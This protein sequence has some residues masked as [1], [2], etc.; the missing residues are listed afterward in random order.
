MAIHLILLAV[1]KCNP[2]LPGSIQIFSNCLGALNKMENLP[3]Y[4]IPTKCSHSDI[5]KNIMVHCSDL[6]FCWLY[7]HVKAHQDD[8]IQY[9]DLS[10]LAQLNYQMDYHAKKA[11]WEAGPVDEEI[12][13]Q[14]PFEPVYIFLGKNK[15]TSDKGDALR[16]W[17]NRKLAK[18]CFYKCNILYVQAFDKVD[19]EIV[20][21]S[22][23]RVPWL[24][25]IW[26]CKQVMGISPAN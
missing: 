12:T 25:Q 1:N 7:S 20:Q 24:F 3:P 16:F 6:S 22:L 17:V 26:V 5:L 2:Y 18:E 11:I 10:Q 13:Q 15:L 8:N 14:F 4:C 9:G 21:S 23:W 19:W